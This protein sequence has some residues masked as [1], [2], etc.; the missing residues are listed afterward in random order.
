MNSLTAR[1]PP[2]TNGALAPFFS[3]DGESVAFFTGNP[4]DLRIVP[5]SGGISRT[6]V[7]DSATPWGGDW[8]ENG[9]IYFTDANARVARVPARGGAVEHLSAPDTTQGAVEHDWPQYLPGGKRLLIQV[10]HTSV[11]DA[12]LGLL[13]VGTGEVTPLFQAAYGRYIPGG[14]IVFATFSG[15]L[16]TVPF[17]P[18]RGEVTGAPTA[19][20]DLIQVDPFSGS[21]QF[22]VS[23]NGTLV[24]MSG[25]G[26]GSQQVVWVDRAGTQAPVDTAWRGQFGTVALSPDGGQLAISQVS[27]EGEHIWV[28]QLPRGPLSRLSY[29]GTAN[30]R[31]TWTRDGRRIAFVSNR[32]GN[33]RQAWIQRADGSADADSLMA[34]PRQ[35]D[36]V[37]FTPDGQGFLYRTGS[38]GTNTRDLHAARLDGGESRTM[39]AGPADEFGPVISPNG[40]W[41]AYVSNQAGR[42]EVFVRSFAD[43][44]A[45]RTQVSVDGGNEPLWAHNG[46]ELFFRSR[47]GEMMSVNVTTGDTFTAG[48]PRILFEATNM[49]TDPYHHAY[50]VSADDRRFLMVNRAINDVAELV[51]VVNWFKELEGR[52]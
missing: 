21:G 36:Q 44:A 33:L 48:Q 40:R 41:F 38:S 37:A 22:A 34:D 9:M 29:G 32:K 52:P 20:A 28:K 4:G 30:V 6:V 14:R 43:P 1:S 10:W 18:A 35:V 46:R 31:P 19:I 39:V 45:G 23:D 17:D 7:R 2:G 49:A 8:A 47:R 15:N 3:R 26:P 11:G 50:D 24:Y 42:D 12:E 16:L 5:V 27:A 51:V 25:G 13:D